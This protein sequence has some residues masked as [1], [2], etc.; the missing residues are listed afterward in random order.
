M[1]AGCEIAFVIRDRADLHTLEVVPAIDGALLTDLVDA[2]ELGH[3]MHPAGNA[4][5]GLVPAHYRF[6]A[7]DRHYRGGSTEAFGPATPV[8]GCECGEWDCWPLLARISVCSGGVTWDEFAQPRRPVRN[9]SG[10]G[11]FHFTREK[12]EDA[13]AD[14]SLALA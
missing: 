9:Y 14:L 7:M 6:G 12:Y 2:Y 13:L 5:G 1:T 8:L 11:P 10:L 3:A 4:Y